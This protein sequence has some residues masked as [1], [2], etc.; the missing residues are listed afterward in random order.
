VI[1]T[2]AHPADLMPVPD[3]PFLLIELNTL[4]FPAA[5]SVISVLAAA[6][7]FDNQR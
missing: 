1:S 4:N 2:S 3:Q 7:S 5:F 6:V